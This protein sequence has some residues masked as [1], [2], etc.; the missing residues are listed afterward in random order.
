MF[1][2]L[3]LVALAVL[4][5]CETGAPISETGEPIVYVSGRIDRV[6]ADILEI[7]VVMRNPTKRIDANRFAG[8]L[9]SGWAQSRGI[10][11]AER[12]R[13]SLRIEG[14]VHDNT[15]RYQLYRLDAPEGK[16]VFSAGL[17]AG[18]CKIEGIPVTEEQ[19]EEMAGDDNI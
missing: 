8:C 14:A 4:A 13:G 5:G 12:L 17:T 10:L 18:V 11:Y 16:Q 7:S 3:A 2:R 1:R 19:I 15:V 9:A 6:D